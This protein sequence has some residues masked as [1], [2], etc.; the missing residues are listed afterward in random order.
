MTKPPF[1]LPRTQSL[2]PDG[3]MNKWVSEQMNVW[4]V[5]GWMEG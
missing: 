4:W 1:L 5:D 2:S 3:W